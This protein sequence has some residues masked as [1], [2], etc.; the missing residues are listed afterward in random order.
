MLASEFAPPFVL[1]L[2]SS[3]SSRRL[4]LRVMAGCVPP[5]A[6]TLLRQGDWAIDKWRARTADPSQ[7]REVF[8]G[9]LES[10]AWSFWMGD[11]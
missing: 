7:W 1:F 2:G 5:R 3:D 11:S 8:S 9:Y 6:I 4:F 10:H